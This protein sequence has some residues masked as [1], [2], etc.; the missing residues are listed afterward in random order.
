MPIVSR[1]DFLP[2]LPSWSRKAL[3]A[4]ALSAICFTFAFPVLWLILTSVRPESASIMSIAA[5]SSRSATLP[6]CCVTTRIVEAFVNSALIATLATIFSLLVT[7][8]SGYMLSRFHRAGI[9]DLVRNDLCVPLRALHLL[10]IAVVLRHPKLGHLRHLP[11]AAAAACGGAHLLLLVADEGFFRRHRSVDGVCRHDRR[12]QP[13]GR[14]CPR[15]RAIS[16]ARDLGACRA[17]LAVHLERVPVRSDP[18]RQP[19]CR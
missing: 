16:A 11:R 14:F 7:V 13:M 1:P 19:G 5:P 8:S 6:R 15:R 17:V 4:L 9:A 3:F 12:L 18:D 2:D 10:G